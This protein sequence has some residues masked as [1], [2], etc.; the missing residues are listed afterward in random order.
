MNEGLAADKPVQAE[1]A[2]R[3]MARIIYVLYLCGLAAGI[4]AV[5]G[6]V[7]AY[8]YRDDAPEW[9]RSHY[10][11]QIRT[12][13]IGLLYIAVGCSLAIVL[14]GFLILLFWFIWVV[15]RVV[16]GLRYLEQQQPHPEP[17][18]WGF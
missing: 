5:I 18:G 8:V 1:G 2:S 16:K 15:V 14:I 12:F 7:M 6:V 13:W 9:L 3:D 17:N 10:Q 11:F 4:T